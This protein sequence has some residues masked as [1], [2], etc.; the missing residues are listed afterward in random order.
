MPQAERNASRRIRRKGWRTAWFFV[1]PFLVFYGLFLVYP[2]FQ[3]AYLS[4]TNSDIAGQGHF[5]GFANYLELARDADFWASVW[6]TVYFI[7]LTVVPNTL[8]GFLFALLVVR[9]RR[10]RLAVLSAFFLPYIL[11]VSV[12]TTAFLWLLDANF[13]IVNYLF[14]SQIAFFADPVWA[15]PGVAI[16]TIWW[17][18]GFNMLLFIAGLQNIPIDL[19]EAAAL[20]GANTFQRFVSIT[21][22]LIWPVTSL[23]LVLQLILQFKIF[24]QVYLLTFGGPYNSTMVVLFYMYREAFQQNRGGY[25][26]AVAIALVLVIILVSAL[27][28]RL[29]NTR[30]K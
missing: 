24:D 21:C 12:V 5:I 29:L 19:Y 26:A 10:L 17:T 14:S 28:F 13:G 23:V 4:L 27:Q 2:A 22:P 18:V 8:V 7:I 1:T 6:H 30:R 25:A 20:D 3:V 9:L 16:V 11:P 15:M